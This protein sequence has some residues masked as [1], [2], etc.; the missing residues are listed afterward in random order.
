MRKKED[1]KYI[2]DKKRLVP[3][4]QTPRSSVRSR[5]FVGEEGGVSRWGTSTPFQNMFWQGLSIHL[6]SFGFF[7]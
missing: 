3:H 6:L 5:T 4:R 2:I 1:K 7:D